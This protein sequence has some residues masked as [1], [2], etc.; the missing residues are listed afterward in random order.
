MSVR[1]IFLL[2]CVCE[3]CGA[4]ETFRGDSN[5]SANYSA[6]QAQWII[7]G[8]N[9]TGR[10]FCPLHPISNSIQPVSTGLN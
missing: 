8:D 10:A 2:F 1:G 6:L 3:V 4:R 5:S 7:K 9:Q